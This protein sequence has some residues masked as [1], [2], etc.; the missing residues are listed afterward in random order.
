MPIWWGP[1]P[2]RPGCGARL[3]PGYAL[4]DSL[5]C[6]RAHA[7][8]GADRP[9]RR[10]AAEHGLHAGNSGLLSGVRTTIFGERARRLTTPPALLDF[11]SAALDGLAAR[12]AGDDWPG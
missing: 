9:V 4:Q 12:I 7:E 2:H 10:A 8:C 1:N 6:F 5:N 11:A 3:L